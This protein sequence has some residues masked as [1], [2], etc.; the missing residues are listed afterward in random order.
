MLPPVRRKLLLLVGWSR[1]SLWHIG[2]AGHFD[3]GVSRSASLLAASQSDGGDMQ[4]VRRPHIPSCSFF[5][6]GPFLVSK[7][8]TIVGVVITLIERWRADDIS[9]ISQSAKSIKSVEIR[10]PNEWFAHSQLLRDLR[11]RYIVENH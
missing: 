7:V 2:P 6:Q 5:R 10:V 3:A 4:P 8:F 1:A 9:E 11:S